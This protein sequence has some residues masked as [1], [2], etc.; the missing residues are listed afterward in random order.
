MSLGR[1]A[2]DPTARKSIPLSIR[3]T[4]READH[5]YACA[6]LRG[7]PLTVVIREALAL[8]STDFSYSQKPRRAMSRL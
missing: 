3:V 4:P 6:S 5:L 1:P 2:L 8:L 7:V